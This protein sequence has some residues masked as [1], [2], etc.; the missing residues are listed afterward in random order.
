MRNTQGKTEPVGKKQPNGFGL[1]DMLG[2]VW[3]WGRDCD[4]RRQDAQDRV[5]R[6]YEEEI[7]DDYGPSRVKVKPSPGTGSKSPPPEKKEESPPGEASTLV[8]D[9]E[10]EPAPEELRTNG[11]CVVRGGSWQMDPRHP[12]ADRSLVPP[13]LR[14]VTLG[15]RVARTLSRDF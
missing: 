3:Q 2:N 12:L 11:R 4:V 6:R 5:T 7:D 13:D 1:Y 15:F 8:Q 10:S 14:S 9:K